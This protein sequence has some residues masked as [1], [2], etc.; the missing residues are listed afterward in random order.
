MKKNP[1]EDLNWLI[2][3][4]SMNDKDK[5]DDALHSFEHQALSRGSLIE[6]ALDD[7]NTPDSARDELSQLQQQVEDMEDHAHLD[8]LSPE[9][10][11]ALAKH[12]AGIRLENVLQDVMEMEPTEY[13]LWAAAHL[14]SSTLQAGW[15]VHATNCTRDIVAHGFTHGVE[16][17]RCLALTN[18]LGDIYK[19]YPGYNYAFTLGDFPRYGLDRGRSKYG[20]DLILLYAPYVYIFHELD[21]EPQA[22]FWE[23]DAINIR[24][25]GWDGVS[26]ILWEEDEDGYE[27]DEYF[28]TLD[29]L[30]QK[31]EE[32]EPPKLNPKVPDDLVL[33]H[34]T[35]PTVI[36]YAV[37]FLYKRKSPKVAARLTAERLN[38]APNLFIDAV[39]PLVVDPDLLEAE[40]WKA[41]AKRALE[42]VARFRPGAT[43]IAIGCVVDAYHLGKRDTAKLTKIVQGHLRD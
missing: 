26:Y 41:M 23:P 29:E 16:D 13:P 25:I 35:H 5:V 32:S 9:A 38:G 17:L 39:N 28:D 37:Q 40:I 36:E 12:L 8:D 1:I 10:S 43:D 14:R 18:H 11:S 20:D 24:Q 3:Y 27:N 34:S 6:D 31:L 21:S 15:L 42:N 19:G 33:C 2:S 22:I 7:P 4:L 30:V